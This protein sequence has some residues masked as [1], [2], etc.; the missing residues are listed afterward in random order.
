MPILLL[1]LLPVPPKFTGESAR[2]KE[3]QRQTN[4]DVLRAAFHLV[5]APLHQVA[6]EGTLMDCVDGK[7]PLCFPILSAWIADHAGH[8]ALQG[9]CSK[10]GPKC[11]VPCEELGGDRRRMYETR[12]YMLYREK[13]LRHE[14]AEA[15]GIG[16][17]FQQLGVKIGSNVFTRLD[18]VSPADLHKLDL[19][20]NNYL[21]LFKHVMALV[22]G[23]LKKHKRQQAVD[24]A[25]KEIAP[26]PGFSIQLMAYGEITQLQAKEI[27]NLGYCISAI[28]A[29]ALRNADISQYQDFK[30]ALKCVTALADFTLMAQYRSHTPDTLSYMESDRQTFYRTKV[31]FL[32]FRTLKATRA[33]ANRYD[34][35][36]R[37]LIPD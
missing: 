22:E 2:A 32:E 7:T 15:A 4:T 16:Q 27:R 12:D 1:A 26:Y 34:P 31:I 19:F 20:H 13:A 23:F 25:W 37:E 5:L 11:E 9:I 35:E 21:G 28:L 3:A 18:R 14:P 10:S 30:S 29:S 8:A 36:L 24:D 33:Q 17:Y 6:R